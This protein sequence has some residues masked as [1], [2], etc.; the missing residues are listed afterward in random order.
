MDFVYVN[1]WVY[2]EICNFVYGLLQSGGLAKI[3]LEKCLKQH[4]YYQCPTTPGLWSHEWRPILF[5]LVVDG[6]NV[7]YISKRYDLHLKTVL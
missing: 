1:G 6:F 5:C 2:F 7:K 3:L 4:D